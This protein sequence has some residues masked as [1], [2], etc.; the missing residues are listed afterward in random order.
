MKGYWRYI[1]GALVLMVIAANS[2]D[3][4]RYVKISSM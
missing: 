4:A 1:I 3:V 2:K